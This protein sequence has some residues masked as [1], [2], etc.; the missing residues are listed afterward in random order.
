MT[1]LPSR[2]TTV[3]TS[4]LMNNRCQLNGKS[5]LLTMKE[6]LPVFEID[7]PLPEAELLDDEDE[8]LLEPE[9]PPVPI[10]EEPP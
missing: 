9:F 5:D 4:S 6:S 1:T 10:D 2:Y 7:I 3:T 8:E